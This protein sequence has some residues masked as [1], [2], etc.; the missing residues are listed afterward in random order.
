MI[1]RRASA[2]EIKRE[3]ILHGMST[4]RQDGWKKAIDGETTIEEVLAVTQIEE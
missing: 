4:M 2:G 1:I 3:A